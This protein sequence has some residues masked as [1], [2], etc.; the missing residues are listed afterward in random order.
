MAVESWS[1][2]F[3]FLAGAAASLNPCGLALLP[4]YLAYFVGG[5]SPGGLLPGLRAGIGMAAG[6][7]GVFSAVGGL[8]SFLGHAL[9]RF[10]PLAAAVVGGLVAFAGLV[11]LLR[12]SFTPSLPVGNLLSE[13]ATGRS[14]RSYFLFGAGYG[15]GSLGCTLPLFLAVITQVLAAGGVLEGFGVLVA[16]GLGMGTVLA[17]LS[18]AV[19]LG[20]GMVI[21]RARGWAVHLRT[22][23]ALGMVL[24]GFS[25]IYLQLSMGALAPSLGR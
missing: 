21:R 1:L 3:A 15:V 25:L 10:V 16:Y 12:P 13:S 8:F 24:A 14:G 22:A 11:M 9:M 23:G 7:L 5:D 2:S 18:G 4:A 19:G 6:T 17:V 20:K